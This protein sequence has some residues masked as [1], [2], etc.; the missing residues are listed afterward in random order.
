MKRIKQCIIHPATSEAFIIT[1][2]ILSGISIA[3][4]KLKAAHIP[5]IL[6]IFFLLIY[7]LLKVPLKLWKP[8]W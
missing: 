4:I 2:I 8:V 7:G 1:L 3:I 5:I 6:A